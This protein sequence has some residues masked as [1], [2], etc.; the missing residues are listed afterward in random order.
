M[1][2]TLAAVPMG[3]VPMN[4]WKGLQEYNQAQA[5]NFLPAQAQ[6]NVGETQAR[7]G[8]LGQQA[9]LAGQQAIGAGITNQISA[10]QL[11]FQQAIYGQMTAG[12]NSTSFGGSADDVIANNGQ[13]PQMQPQA[14]PAAAT[15]GPGP[16][17]AIGTYAT[18]AES[19]GAPDN[20]TGAVPT[21]VQSSPLPAIGSAAPMAPTA[22]PGASGVAP[23]LQPSQAGATGTSGSGLPPTFTGANGVIIP[24]MAFPIPRYWLPGYAQAQDKTK[25]IGELMNARNSLLRQRAMETLG[26]NGQVDPDKWNVAVKQAFNDGLIS[27]TQLMNFYNHPANAQAFI[28]SVLPPEQSPWVQGQ[29]AAAKGWGEVAPAIAR[30]GGVAGAEFPYKVAETRAAPQKL[31]PGERTYYPPV[32]GGG[33]P[34]GPQ[35][36]P[37]AGGQGGPA[38]AAPAEMP[39][40]DPADPRN[41]AALASIEDPR[42]KRMAIAAAAAYDLPVAMVVATGQTESGFTPFPARG[43]SG[44]HGT[45][46]VMPQTAQT[47]GIPE[48]QL[49]DPFTNIM[50]GAKYLKEQLVAAGG[51]PYK[52]GAMYNRPAG[53]NTQYAQK[54]RQRY[55]SYGAAPGGGAAAAAPA[56]ATTGGPG[57]AAPSGINVAPAP[58]GGYSVGSDVTPGDVQ[59][60]RNTSDQVKE[61]QNDLLAKSQAAQKANASIDQ[62]RLDSQTWTGAATAPALME[63]TAWLDG[64][65]RQINAAAGKEIMGAPDKSVGDWQAFNKNMGDLVRTA[66]RDTSG[67]AAFQEFQMIAR[68]LPS[69]EMSDQG[70]RNMFDTL[71]GINDWYIAKSNAAGS[72]TGHEPPN[73]FDSNWGNQVSPEVFILNRMSPQ[74][75]RVFV[76]HASQ[77]PE[78]RAL[79]GTIKQE[80]AALIQQGLLPTV[81]PIPTGRQLGQ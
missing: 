16:G 55:D 8:L 28:N 19:A 42:M 66:V 30:A 62:G 14:A 61:Y 15:A 47:L 71:Q 57:Q 33:A 9:A 39:H 63:A 12:L 70:K 59:T 7:V 23:A 64:V 43:S 60:Q 3:V 18:T 26:P 79:L 50:A 65:R 5:S 69:D 45:M 21:P 31:Q 35:A 78:G 25:A 13:M 10:L 34:G 22:T 37:G 73:K 58:G 48:S 72:L 67:R 38:A 68:N 2:G 27:N 4:P 6:A 41:A 46:Q 29:V 32:Q 44:E 1:S 36:G 74:D 20:A 49:D 80:R 52:A 40:F 75:Q 81:N 11:P 77:T 56:P 17:G 76:T 54:W 51:D 24:G 53:G